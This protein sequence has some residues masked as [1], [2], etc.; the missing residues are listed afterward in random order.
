MALQHVT[1]IWPG[2]AVLLPT[3]RAQ[4]DV[5][6]AT[7]LGA[8][9]YC[10]YHP[11]EGVELHL[12]VGHRSRLA[13]PSAAPPR[14][15]PFHA[16][17]CLRLTGRHG[18][19]HVEQPIEPRR[20]HPHLRVR[21]HSGPRDEIAH[22]GAADRAGAVGVCGQV[23]LQQRRA[24]GRRQAGRHGHL[25]VVGAAASR[26]QRACGGC[27]RGSQLAASRLWAFLWGRYVAQRAGRTSRRDGVP[28]TW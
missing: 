3:F 16:V 9:Y 13:H 21:P 27:G 28:A 1:R 7:H 23:Q 6:P 25:R 26:R 8:L 20:E 4:S 12:P 2:T 14:A 10:A 22:L 19:L 11:A 24:V 17:V 15:A 5:R 18:A